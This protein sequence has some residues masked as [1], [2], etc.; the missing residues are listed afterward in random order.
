MKPSPHDTRGA[1]KKGMDTEAQ[2]VS[3]FKA[4]GFDVTKATREQD[5]NEHW[6]YLI[7]WTGENRLFAGTIVRKGHTFTVDV[8]SKGDVAGKVWVEIRNVHGKAGWLYGKADLLAFQTDRGFILVE[9]ETLKQWVEENVE[10]EYVSNK[11]QALL[12]VYT[13]RGRRDML[14]LLQDYWIVALAVAKQEVV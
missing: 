8:K 4:I 6:D 2:F 14:T 12:K 10:K 3:T 1:M 13:R 7:T 11:S 5:I 9:R